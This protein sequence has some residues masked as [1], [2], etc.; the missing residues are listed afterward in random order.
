[1]YITRPV[2][3][4]EIIGRD[5]GTFNLMKMNDEKSTCIDRCLEVRAH[6]IEDWAECCFIDSNGVVYSGS[7]GRGFCRQFPATKQH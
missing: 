4:R 5:E 1:L 7:A 2:I 3:G 6:E